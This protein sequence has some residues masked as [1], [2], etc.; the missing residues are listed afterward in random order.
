MLVGVCFNAVAA[1]L[2]ERIE[3]ADEPQ[4]LATIP[5]DQVREV[6]LLAYDLGNNHTVTVI[7]PNNYFKMIPVTQGRLRVKK[8]AGMPDVKVME[9]MSLPDLAVCCSAID[10]EDNIENLS[11]HNI[12]WYQ[13]CASIEGS[14]E[15]HRLS[16][17]ILA[18]IKPD[19]RINGSGADY[20]KCSHEMLPWGTAQTIQFIDQESMIRDGAKP[21]VGFCCSD[22]GFGAGGFLLAASMCT[23]DRGWLITGVEKDERMVGIHRQ[24]M[25][26]V[27]ELCPAMAGEMNELK[28]NCILGEV[29]KVNCEANVTQNIEQADLV[30]VNNFLFHDMSGRGLQ[31]GSINGT[32]ASMLC[33]CKVGTWVVTTALIGAT[34]NGKTLKLWKKLKWK[35]SS[36]SWSPKEIDGYLYH[37]VNC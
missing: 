6:V 12:K 36:F 29:S 19:F 28:K 4:E 26:R 18:A 5:F 3:H 35:K 11:N 1:E 32:I 34:R 17:E 22:I 25:A 2:V 8:T 27:I 10:F 37:V 14:F 33:G 20:G 15:K 7:N 31:E 9:L 21:S 16:M 23:H 13:S 24:W 30:F